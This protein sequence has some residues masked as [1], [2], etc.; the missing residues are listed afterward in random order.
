MNE[1]HWAIRTIRHGRVKV[2]GH[3][4]APSS[5]HFPYDGRLDGRRFVFAR[6]LDIGNG[7]RPFLYLWGSETEY[8]TGTLTNNGL[9]VI[10]G[11]LPWAWWRIL[12]PAKEVVFH[13][14][15]LHQIW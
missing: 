5:Q 11:T 7:Y 12:T 14:D 10:D 4:Y 15:Q 9:E 8:R 2:Y 13:N 3:Y 6:Y 1:T